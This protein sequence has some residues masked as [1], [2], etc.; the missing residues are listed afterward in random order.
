MDMQKL[1]RY[2]QYTGCLKKNG[3]RI[4]NYSLKTKSLC[5]MTCI[6]VLLSCFTFTYTVQKI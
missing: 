1:R 5:C 4:N 2:L 3:T 6:T